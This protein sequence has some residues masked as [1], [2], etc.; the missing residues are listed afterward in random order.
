MRISSTLKELDRSRLLGFDPYDR[1]KNEQHLLDKLN[2]SRL[3][4]IIAKQTAHVDVGKKLAFAKRVWV[5]ERWYKLIRAYPNP[6]FYKKGK[7][8]FEAQSVWLGIDVETLR[9]RHSRRH[10]RGGARYY[11]DPA[12]QDLIELLAAAY[13]DATGNR[14]LGYNPYN[15]RACGPLTEFIHHCLKELGIKATGHAIRHRVSRSRKRL[16]SEPPL[17][18]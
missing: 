6:Q 2:A 15:G 9:E 13:T 11:G 3:G 7:P 12:T 8:D 17:S 18:R 4:G 10:C 16:S 14:G 1:E 5:A